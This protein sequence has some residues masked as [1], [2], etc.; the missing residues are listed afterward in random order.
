MKIDTLH[1]P[2]GINFVCV[3]EDGELMGYVNLVFVHN[4]VKCKDYGLIEGLYVNKKYRR[5]K[6]ATKLLEELMYKAAEFGCYKVIATSRFEREYVHKLYEKYG[7]KKWGY[8]FR[9]DL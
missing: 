9:L 7:M 2:E 4:P 5:K 3:K 1:T 6:I 8:E